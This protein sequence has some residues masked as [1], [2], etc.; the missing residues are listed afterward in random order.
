VWGSS[1]GHLEGRQLG[2]R[3]CEHQPFAGVARI[4]IGRRDPLAVRKAMLGSLLRRAA[5]RLRLKR[6]PRRGGR[7][8]RVRARLQ[9]GPRGH[10][11]EAQG[12]ALL[13][14]TR[15]RAIVPAITGT[16]VLSVNGGDKILHTIN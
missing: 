5:P 15:T 10:R 14:S 11:V 16:F 2:Q 4:K 13:S 1:V 7:P 12:L 6:A 9:D 8:A 3:G